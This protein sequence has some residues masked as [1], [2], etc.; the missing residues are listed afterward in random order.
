MTNNEVKYA[1]KNRLPVIY[2]GIR[3]TY[4]SEFTMMFVGPERVPKFIVGLM[5]KNL[6]SITRAEPEKVVFAED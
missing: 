3:Y 6:N 4:I 2:K 5:D 1:M